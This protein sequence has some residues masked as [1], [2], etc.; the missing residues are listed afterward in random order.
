[1]DAPFA[2]IVSVST[3]EHVGFDE[4]PRTPGG[5]RAALDRLYDHCLAPGG[6]MF[7]TV[8]LG[9]NPVVDDAVFGRVRPLGEI[10][11]YRRTGLRNLWHWIEPSRWPNPAHVPRYSY[12]RHHPEILAV[13]H[14]RRP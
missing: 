5:F 1:V 2:S 8:P 7:V 12:R 11:L 3:L 4:T 6:E 14:A 9:Y 13:G 10:D